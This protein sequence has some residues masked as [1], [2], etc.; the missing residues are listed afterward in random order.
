[1]LLDKTLAFKFGKLE[2]RVFIIFC[3]FSMDGTLDFLLDLP[4]LVVEA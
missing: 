4:R 2:V 1:M 3:F